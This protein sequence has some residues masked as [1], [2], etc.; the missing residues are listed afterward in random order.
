[1]RHSS[2]LDKEQ[3]ALTVMQAE[4][5]TQLLFHMEVQKIQVWPLNRHLIISKIL[6]K[7]S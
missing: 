4:L 3:E 5:Q 1:M 6:S 7:T 2:Q